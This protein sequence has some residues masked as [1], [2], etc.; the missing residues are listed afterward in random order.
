[1][2]LRFPATEKPLFGSQPLLPGL[3]IGEDVMAPPVP[4]GS[5]IPLSQ[6]LPVYTKKAEEA[7]N[8]QTIPPSERVRVRRYFEALRR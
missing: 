7:M 1:M 4:T 2:H 8:T 3:A 6:I 5:G